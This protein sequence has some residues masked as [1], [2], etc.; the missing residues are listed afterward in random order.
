MENPIVTV[1]T[2][3]VPNNA[4]PKKLLSYQATEDSGGEMN[5][6]LS[7]TFQTGSNTT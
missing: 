3:M 1:T 4:D 7:Y 5:C 2:V 6:A